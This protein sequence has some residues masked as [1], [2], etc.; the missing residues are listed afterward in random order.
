MST[1]FLL[2]QDKFL[3]LDPKNKIEII[4]VIDMK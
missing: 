1:K 3:V 2:V 4:N